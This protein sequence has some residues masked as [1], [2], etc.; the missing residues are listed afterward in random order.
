MKYRPLKNQADRDARL[1]RIKK[2][3][4][5]RQRTDGEPN[6]GAIFDPDTTDHSQETVVWDPDELA[7]A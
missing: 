3:H 7:G 1:R 4:K 5:R 2:I 6:N